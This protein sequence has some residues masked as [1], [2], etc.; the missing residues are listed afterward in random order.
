MAC[1]CFRLQGASVFTLQDPRFRR[2]EFASVARWHGAMARVTI[3]SITKTYLVHE[4]FMLERRF[5]QN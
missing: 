3:I 5:L 4:V 1:A 2:F